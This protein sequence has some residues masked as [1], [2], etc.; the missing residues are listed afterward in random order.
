MRNLVRTFLACVLA[1]CTVICA[2]AS[3]VQISTSNN[4]CLEIENLNELSGAEYENYL[5]SVAELSALRVS[6]D[7]ISQ[8][9]QLMDYKNSIYYIPAN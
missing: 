8:D 2:S 3:D 5:Q 6:D 4:V 9:E 7:V 1:V